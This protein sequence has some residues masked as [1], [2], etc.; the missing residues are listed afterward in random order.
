MSIV[1]K[2]VVFPLLGDMFVSLQHKS[3]TTIVINSLYRYYA[4][5]EAG[6]LLSDGTHSSKS[7]E[8]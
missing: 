3:L 2:V 5:Q 6:D 1:I 8:R 4:K 7:K